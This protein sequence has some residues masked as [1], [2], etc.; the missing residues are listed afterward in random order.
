MRILLVDDHVLFRQG[1]VSLLNAQPDFEVIDQVG[2]VATAVQSAVEKRPDLI[3][4]DL[5]LPDGTGL[6]ATQQILAKQPDAKIIIL[7]V[8]EE[9]DRLFA[10]LRCGAKGY[11]LKN[12][13]IGKLL[14]FLRGV[15][16]GEAA[17]S[18]TMVTRVFDEFARLDPVKR[19]A[20]SSK[21]DNKLTTREMQVLKELTT[22]A[23][24]REIANRLVIAENTVKN[25]IRNILSKLN[26]KNR[27]EAA[28]LAQ[29]ME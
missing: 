26:L 12:V 11:L 8:H 28:R 13:P 14:S 15:E 16:V 29:R 9:D 7:T 27:R 24:N 3:L 1:L 2:T 21:I 20:T 18:A 22:G 6:D 10:A 25:H 19:Q 4:M 5:S 23:S 17:I